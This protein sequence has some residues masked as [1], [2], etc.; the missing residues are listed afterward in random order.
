MLIVFCVEKTK[1]TRKHPYAEKAKSCKCGRLKWSV[2]NKGY[3]N[4]N[5]ENTK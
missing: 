2:G 1:Y 4:Q 5:Y 3:T